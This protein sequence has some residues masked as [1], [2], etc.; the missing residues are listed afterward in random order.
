MLLPVTKR[1]AGTPG[2]TT[3]TGHRSDRTGIET[4]HARLR[5]DGGSVDGG[6]FDDEAN[7]GSFD[8][9]ST[10]GTDGQPIDDGASGTAA[11]SPSADPAGPRPSTLDDVR[12]V[13][14]EQASTL[15]RCNWCNR[16]FTGRFRRRQFWS[17]EGR[18]LDVACGVGTNLEYLPSDVAYVGIDASPEVLQRAAKRYE[19][20]TVGDTLREMDAQD[21]A[22][23]DDSFDTVISS[24][25]TCTF[26]D[27][28][29]ALAEMGRVCAPGGRI[30]L[31]EHGRSDVGAIARL[32]DRFADWHYENHACRWNQ[33]PIALVE[34]SPLTVRDH[35]SAALGILTGIEALPP[36][37]S[38]V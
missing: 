8:D 2:W 5:T 12:E 23:P 13:Y 11:A 31:L 18:V 22:F 38:E 3:L 37:A 25:S 16:L 33:E 29:A 15:D 1:L 27:P 6:S 14:A 35:W 21:L 19:Q 28:Q 34:Q 10:H 4:E 24:L 20:L 9:D 30:L 26:P 7:D 17:A 32:Q 36:N